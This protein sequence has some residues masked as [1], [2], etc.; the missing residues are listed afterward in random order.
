MKALPNYTIL[1]KCLLLSV[2]CHEPC[3]PERGTWHLF[4]PGPVQSTVSL[5]STVN[6]PFTAPP[7]VPR[8][9]WECARQARHRSSITH[10]QMS[11][12]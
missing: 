5:Q 10:Q 7:P 6:Q 3:G 4:Y 1:G 12:D 8:P 9:R 11:F 2:R